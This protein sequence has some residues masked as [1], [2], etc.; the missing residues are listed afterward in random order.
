MRDSFSRK[1]LTLTSNISD[2]APP[3][4]EQKPII[5]VNIRPVAKDNSKN[6][7]L[8]ILAANK[9]VSNITI[10]L[11]NAKIIFFKFNPP[12]KQDNLNYIIYDV[13]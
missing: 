12:I 11:K 1:R 13:M 10:K 2:V 6:G 8:K 9:F 7:R 4:L 5:K 3:S